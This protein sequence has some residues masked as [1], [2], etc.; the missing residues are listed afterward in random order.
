MFSKPLRVFNPK[1]CRG[2]LH[3]TLVHK[4]DNVDNVD[5]VDNNVEDVDN[6]NNINV[7]N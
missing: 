3:I 5:N 2:R 4:E 7:D 1:S 6:V